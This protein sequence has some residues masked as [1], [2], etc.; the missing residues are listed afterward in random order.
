MSSDGIYDAVVI[1]SG[2]NGLC[3]AIALA[4]AGRRVLVREAKA[5]IGGSCRSAGLT[6]P[7]FVH[8][9]C[10]TV[11]ALAR[12]SPF[13]R[14]LPLQEHGLELLEPAAAYAHPLDDGSAAVAERSVEATARS[15]GADASAYVRHVGPLVAS[16]AKLAPDLLAPLRLPR[17]PLAM[18]AFGIHAIRSARGLAEHWFAGE[19]ARAMLAGVAAHAILPFE[20]TGSAAMGLVL[21]LSAHVAGWPVARGGSQRVVD[22]LASYLRSLGGVIATDAPVETLDELGRTR[23]ILC[24]ITPRQLLRIAGDRLPAG[25][26]KRLERFRYGPGVW[27]VDWALEGPIPWAAAECARAGTVHVGGTL[28]EIA[29]AERTAWEGRSS[30]RPFVLLV[31]PTVVDPSRA[32]AGKHVGWAYCHVPHGLTFD[33]TGR[34]EAQVERFAPGFRQRILARSVMGPAEMERHNPNLVG[35]DITG[36]AM[37]LSQLFTRPVARLD[38]YAVP[39]DGVYFCSASTPPGGGVHGMC[40]YWAAQA[41]LRRELR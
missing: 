1:G 36:G 2:P 35:G 12:V 11:Q 4:R 22:A 34:I 41:A 21:A 15:L 26:R 20:W 5:T 27:K 38:P 23:A 17:H 18:A 19:R 14:T 32:P 37:L 33:M 3:A 24:D 9:V 39:I 25:Y 28:D 7:G 16:W 40:G 6:L 8:D 29:A 30:E 13:M 31:Q 10:S